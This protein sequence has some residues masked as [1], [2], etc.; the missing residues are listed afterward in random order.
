MTRPLPLPSAALV[1]LLALVSACQSEPPH[2]LE[3]ACRD[4]SC[5]AGRCALIES[6][7][8]CL[9]DAG[10][11]ADGLRCVEDPP[12]PDPTPCEPNPCTEPHRTVCAVEDTTYQCGCDAGYLWRDGQCVELT[13][14][15]CAA[16]PW[17]GGDTFEPDDCP[18]RAVLDVPMGQPLETRT[19]APVGDVDWYRLQVREGVTYRVR[20]STSTGLGLYLDVVTEDGLR[21]VMADHQD[22]PQVGVH[23]KAPSSAPL[24]VRLSMYDPATQGPYTL[25]LEEER[26]DDYADTADGARPLPA[27]GVV[28]SGRV[29]FH[30]DVDLHALPLD[31]A[32]STV[33]DVVGL[34][35]GVADLRVE[36][37]APDGT[38]VVRQ[39]RGSQL[40][41]NLRAPV[42]GRYLLAVRAT[43]PTATPHYRLAFQ[44]LGPDD[45][46]DD[47]ASASPLS[48]TPAPV[49]ATFERGGDVDVFTFVPVAG[50]HYRVS[51]SAGTPGFECEKL[52]YLQGERPGFWQWEQVRFT[53]SAAAPHVLRVRSFSGAVGTYAVHLEDLGADDHPNGTTSGTPVT[54]GG[55]AITGRLPVTTDVD[56]FTFQAQ[57]G[58]L[59]RFDC[60]NPQQWLA[61]SLRDPT[62][63][64]VGQAHSGNVLIARAHVDGPHTV[65]LATSFSFLTT[66][67]S[68]QLTEAG[69]DDHGDT[70]ATATPMTSAEGAGA[71]D[72]DRDVD[73]LSAQ[74]EP[75][76]IYRLTVTA[77]TANAV[78]VSITSGSG[79][80]LA[81]GQAHSTSQVF[82]FKATTGTTAFQVSSLYYPSLLGTWSLRLERAGA[83]DH[84]DTPATATPVTVP[85]ELTGTLDFAAD[86]D[87][88]SFPATAG[89]IYR[90]HCPQVGSSGSEPSILVY[91]GAR[92]P[93]G[94]RVRVQHEVETSGTLA[95]AVS[96]G[97]AAYRCTVEDVG[98][99]DHADSA[100]GANELAAPAVGTGALETFQDVDAF[101]FRPTPGRIYRFA[102]SQI[103][104]GVR[105]RGPEGQVL[106]EKQPGFSAP[107]ALSWEAADATLVSMEVF[108]S[109][110]LGTYTYAL[111]DVGTDDHGDTSAAATPLGVGTVGAS[112][113]SFR[114]VDVFSFSATAGRV[115]R[116]RCSSSTS[117]WCEVKVKDPTGHD[118][119]AFHEALV[120][121]RYVIEVSTSS[122][123]TGTY[124]LH[125]EDLGPDD[126]ADTATGATPLPEGSIGVG[127]Y[128]ET[129]TDVDVFS[130]SVTAPRAYRIVCKPTGPS[131]V[132]CML[133]VRDARGV[134]V[135]SSGSSSEWVS[136]EAPATG[137]L[138]VEVS[139]ASSQYT[140]TYTVTLEDLGLDDAGNTPATAAP[141]PLSQR[142]ERRFETRSDVDV[143]ALQLSGGQ[144]YRVELHATATLQLAVL[145]AGGAVLPLDFTREFR[146]PTGGTYY[147]Q[148]AASEAGPYELQVL[149]SF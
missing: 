130:L 129:F 144:R 50:H 26:P 70:P 86:V 32:S 41:I 90:I 5:G 63:D 65:Q 19:L 120:G 48:A 117:P 95:V 121:G 145:T 24:L 34:Q 149:P 126:H 99:D 52:L 22:R 61:L 84:G 83:D 66:P 140:G 113:E 100:V 146:P 25:L 64:A 82:A 40:R 44:Q 102:C 104:C 79:A 97:N 122:M 123:E 74:T 110:M 131:P 62:G 107:T 20:A 98:T 88:F 30:G 133:R 94:S 12:L 38:T 14:P 138:T 33:I 35:E 76:G 101:T 96:G 15:T 43:D 9:C 46:G 10:Y 51:C 81:S 103:H 56:A 142:V 93:Q 143:F 42:G 125:L 21:P 141:L 55:P 59:Y 114:D 77:G 105:V 124:T 134:L 69:T 85:G 49:Q 109:S 118:V 47:E 147:L 29:D 106:A 4:V 16:E 73:V 92:Q 108:F 39:G 2:A 8:A 87:V 17:P 37:L 60:A 67:Y 111:E 45:H 89:R 116:V 139:S 13:R 119:P 3:E 80:V 31:A 23:F 36:L 135:V 136:F 57:A 27:G 68:C 137:T 18:E 53:A 127:G 112:F 91:E 115:Y 1:A 132:G 78:S 54:V 28:V 6:G 148:L 11:H 58:H 72:Y 71:I 7:P 75:G 128:L